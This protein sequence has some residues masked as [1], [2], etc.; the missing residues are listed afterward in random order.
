MITPYDKI[1]YFGFKFDWKSTLYIENCAWGEGQIGLGAKDFSRGFN[2]ND[3]SVEGA[4]TQ[5]QNYF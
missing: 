4:K 3:A 1:S 2:N 5:F